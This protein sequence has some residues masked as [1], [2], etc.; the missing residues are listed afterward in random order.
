MG[1]NIHPGSF[2]V[3]A[4]KKVNHVKNMKMAPILKTIYVIL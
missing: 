4:V 3:T 2:G 1:L